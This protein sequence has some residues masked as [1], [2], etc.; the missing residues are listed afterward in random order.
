MKRK[1]LIASCLVDA[2]FGEPHPLMGLIDYLHYDCRIS[3]KRIASMA[4]RHFYIPRKEALKAIDYF[5]SS[6]KQ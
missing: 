1:E 6:R 5:L 3:K 2:A 4:S